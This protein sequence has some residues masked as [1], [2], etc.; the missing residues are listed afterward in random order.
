MKIS[1]L[2]ATLGA[3]AAIL[4]ATACEPIDQA[5]PNLPASGATAKSSGKGKRTDRPEVTYKI[6]GSAR[7][8]DITYS[9]PSGQEQ[10]GDERLPWRRT[11]TARKGEVLYVSAQNAGAAGTVTCEISI[12]GKTVKR[13]RSS[14]AYA[15]VTCDAMVGF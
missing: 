2:T 12:N 14:G 13:A 3:V 15:V 5:D 6:G 1:M 10:A 11:F 9:T 4:G 7:T 8:G